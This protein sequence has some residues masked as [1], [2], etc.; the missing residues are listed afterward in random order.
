MFVETPDDVRLWCGTEGV[1]PAVLL[2]PGRGDSTDVFPVMF[3]DRL[4]A[5]GLTAVR[6][7]PRD[8]G[9]SGDGGDTYT[10]GTM[11]DDV[12]S[13]AEALRL[14][15]VHVVGLSMAGLISVDLATRAPERVASITFLSAMSPDPDAGFGPAFFAGSELDEVDAILAA[16]G[17][18]AED[19]RSWVVEEITRSRRRADPRPQARERHQN[20]ALRFGWPELS[21]LSK[22][23]APTV[24][25][26]GSADEVLPLAHAEALANGIEGATLD[27]ID[28]MGHLPRRHEWVRIADI[29][30]DHVSSVGSAKRIPPTLNERASD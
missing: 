9:R 20:A 16:M 23:F 18:T 7:D 12:I 17:A 5:S 3:T 24:V 29:V 27:I 10:L 14:A 26:H 22:I 21:R 1:G 15:Q 30:I 11:A 2:V 8:T 6:L 28:G 13:V 19:D 25:V 4:V